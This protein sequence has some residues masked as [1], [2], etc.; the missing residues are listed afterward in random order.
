M[1][2]KAAQR[3]EKAG[4]TTVKLMV[5]EMAVITCWLSATVMTVGYE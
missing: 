3:S 4:V 2:A 1:A 5:A